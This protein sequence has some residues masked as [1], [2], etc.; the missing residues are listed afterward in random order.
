MYAPHAPAY[1]IVPTR[2]GHYR[3]MLWL[4]D[5]EKPGAMRCVL[6]PTG[7][8]RYV[9]QRARRAIEHALIPGFTEF[10]GMLPG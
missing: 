5:P 9:E 1:L 10:P 7:Y 6:G 8:R 4:P 2:D 3:S